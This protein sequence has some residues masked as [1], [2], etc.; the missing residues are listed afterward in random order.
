MLNLF[1]L[2]TKSLK[3]WRGLAVESQKR[4][5]EHQIASGDPGTILKD[6]DALLQFVG[7]EGIVTKSRNATLPIE[8][9]PKLNANSSQPIQF[10]LKRALLRDYPNLAGIFILTR[11][12]DLLQIKGNRLVVNPEALKVWRGL[13]FTEQY[14]TLLEAFLFQAES[15]VLGGAPTREDNEIVESVGAFL[16]LLSDRWRNFDQYESV[17]DLGPQGYLPP[18]RLFLLQQFGMIQIYQAKF[19]PEGGSYWGGRGWLVGGAKI[20]PWGTAVTWALLK[21][22]EERAAADEAEEEADG[23]EQPESE[24]EWEPAEFGMLQPVFQP[25]FP[26]WQTVYAR[27]VTEPRRGT[28]VFKV[29]LARWY[30][31]GHDGSVWRRIAVPP[32]ITLDALAEVILSAFKLDNDHMYDFRYRDRRGRNRVYNHPYTNEVP[33]TLDVGVG[34][35]DLALKDEMLFT[36]DYGDK[37]QFKVKLEKIEVGLSQLRKAKVIETAGEAPAQYPSY[38]E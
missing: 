2:E 23:A 25:Y 28:H 16:G 29:A 27:P 38:E 11:V 14:F 12:M 7:P 37:W 18:W 24:E 9:L 6:V 3:R 13:N 8:L 5:T 34:E 35:T 10:G 1:R 22:L 31:G 17:S 4:L 36:F 26:E 19:P 30:G 33:S 21:F 20:T 32:D 15:T